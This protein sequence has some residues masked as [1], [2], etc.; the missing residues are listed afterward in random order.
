MIQTKFKTHTSTSPG[1]KGACIFCTLAILPTLA[2]FFLL[3]KLKNSPLHLAERE[4]RA[5]GEEEG[6]LTIPLC[7]S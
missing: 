4:N 1:V 7:P 2:V 5:R 3:L 6:L